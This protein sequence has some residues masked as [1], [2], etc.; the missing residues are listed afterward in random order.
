MSGGRVAD[1]FAI[2][3]GAARGMGAAHGR[4]LVAGG[5]RVVITDVKDDAGRALAAE[6]GDSVAYRRLDVRYLKAWQAIGAFTEETSGPASILVN[7]AG[8]SFMQLIDKMTEEEYRHVIDINQIVPS[9]GIQAAVPSIRKAGGGSI[10]NVSSSAGMTGVG[11][12]AAYTATKFALRGITKCAVLDLGG[13]NIRVNTL[14]PGFV[15]TPM[16][17]DFVVREPKLQPIKRIC[18]PGNGW[19][20]ALIGSN[21]TNNYYKNITNSTPFVGT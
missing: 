11:A 10:I 18:Q 1:E 6:I 7:K 15:Y 8:I 9:L 20:L 17:T 2:V 5:A 21:L 13:E 14:H 16:A 19:E 4:T 12:H 3:T